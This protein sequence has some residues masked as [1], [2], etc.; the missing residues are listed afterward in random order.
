MQIVGRRA[1]KRQLMEAVDSDKAALVAVVGRRRIG[2]T[3]LIRQVYAD[4]MVFDITGLHNGDLYDQL[5]HFRNTLLKSGYLDAVE[6]PQNW[7]SAFYM[8]EN[9]LNSL[10]TKKKKVLFFD[11]LPWMDTPRSKFLMAFENFWNSY[12]TKRDDMVVVICGS[13]ASWM[14]KKIVNNKGGLY[15]RITHK[16]HLQPFT[17]NETESFLQAK[18]IVWSRYDIVQFYMMVG[19]VPYYLDLVQK[20]ES[21]MQF[22]ERACFAPDGMLVSE[23]EELFASL[24]HNSYRHY[25]IVEALST[26][27]KGLVRD[28]LLQKSGLATGGTFTETLDELLASGFVEKQVP[29]GKEKQGTLYRLADPFMLF[30]QKFM[31][32]KK[33][34]QS[35]SWVKITDTPAWYAWAGLAFENVCL[36]HIKQI[37]EALKLTAIS[38]VV[39]GWRGGNENGETQI[40]LLIERADRIIHVCEIKFSKGMFAI[41]KPY[42]QELRQKLL[43]FSQTPQNKRNTLFLTMISTFGLQQN[44][45]SREIVQ[46]ELTMDDMFTGHPL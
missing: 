23:F 26:I 31:K 17:L 4:H 19:G 11:E 28:A 14:I 43:V 2:K 40:D 7:L 35:G 41:D 3:F 32:G 34:K 29:W 6:I 22:V 12:C 5:E 44:E 15:N 37:K 18:G 38:T 21:V 30:H 45:Y 27:K 8:L 46:N 25:K 16:I 39:A 33:G 20:G 36:Q 9:Y 42:A 13:A 1:E 10:K 24:F